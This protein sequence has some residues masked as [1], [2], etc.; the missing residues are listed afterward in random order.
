MAKAAWDM[1]H[2]STDLAGAASRRP[3]SNW[4]PP[5]LKCPHEAAAE[6]FAELGLARFLM[7][8]P[9]A[10]EALMLDLQRF[11]AVEEPADRAA[12][13][14]PANGFEEAT[15]EEAAPGL[16]A[17]AFPAPKARSVI[18]SPS[19]SSAASLAAASAEATAIALSPGLPPGASPE[20]R[21]ADE[22]IPCA[23]VGA[24]TASSAQD[25]G[26]ETGPWLGFDMSQPAEWTAHDLMMLMYRD[27]A[28]SAR[29]KDMR[30]KTDGDAGEDHA[31][32]EIG[33]ASA[34]DGASREQAA[35]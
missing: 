3:L 12:G 19:A 16:P 32:A 11:A 15:Q 23:S 6:L 13:P 20:A 27:R 5:A 9:D 25:G 21:I 14:Q 10:G 4:T 1:F 34:L 30:P 31:D 28:A 33:A 29:Q 2:G 17:V 7:Q 26:N 8:A 35:A 18:A 22:A 24:D